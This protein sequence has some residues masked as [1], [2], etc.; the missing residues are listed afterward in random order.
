M[1]FHMKKIIYYSLIASF[2]IVLGFGK[3][4]YSRSSNQ[5]TEVLFHQ[6]GTVSEQ[7]RLVFEHLGT[8][9]TTLA[10]ANT[11]AQKNLL[12]AG[13]RWDK[14]EETPLFLSMQKNRTLLINDLKAL[15]MIDAVVATQREYTYA[16]L[17][18]ATRKS[19]TARFDYLAELIEQGYTFKY[20]VLLGGERQLRDVEKEGLPETVTTE[21]QMMAYVC[22]QKPTLNAQKIILVNAPMIQKEDGTVTRPTTDS[23]LAHFAQ[24]A[25]EDGS[26]LVISG[27]PYNVRQ[28]KVAQRVLDQS[29]FPTEGAGG[30][31]PENLDIFV[32]MDEFARTIYEE[33]VRFKSG[34]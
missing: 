18:G 10:D 23:T 15:G 33:Y 29:R 21:A 31:M 25:P 7:L 32:V 20:I 12:R 16:L 3:M 27:N 1:E 24:I 6:H 26:C 8:S 4:S 2:I 22:A 13:E 14:Q 28:T 5:S 34:K 30:S 9:I 19:V 17:M 11:F